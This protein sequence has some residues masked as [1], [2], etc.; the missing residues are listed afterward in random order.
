MHAAIWEVQ[1]K[2]DSE[3]RIELALQYLRGYDRKSQDKIQRSKKTVVN[4]VK[5]LKDNFPD[6]YV[7]QEGFFLPGELD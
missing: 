6:S 1:D 2:L 4:E 5:F 3:D 7:L